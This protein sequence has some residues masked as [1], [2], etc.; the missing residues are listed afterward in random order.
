MDVLRPGCVLV[1]T[2]R[3]TLV[4]PSAALRALESGRLAAYAVDTFATE[5]PELDALLIHDRV[6]VTPHLGGLTEESV[7]RAAEDAVRN[8]IAGLAETT[9]SG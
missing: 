3:W 7:R 1:N 2:A 8:L 9:R 6:I 4:D 5:P